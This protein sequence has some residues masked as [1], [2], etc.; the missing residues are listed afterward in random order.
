MEREQDLE[1]CKDVVGG[2]K[3]F[4]SELNLYEAQFFGFTPQTCVLR[5]CNAFQDC[6]YDIL[7]LVEKIC[8]EQLSAGGCAESE[9]QLRAGAREC[10][11]RLKQFL[12]ERLKRLSERMG[13]LLVNRC[14]SVPSTV[15]LPE[16]QPHRDYP[17]DLQVGLF[18][19]QNCKAVYEA[20]L[21]GLLRIVLCWS[22]FHLC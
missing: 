15:L 12:E 17:Q 19:W 6:L 5:I 4:S 7:P 20:V 10:S 14:F 22:I 8:V 18:F 3:L 13:P 16:D 11:Q 2:N 1:V 9:E 21:D